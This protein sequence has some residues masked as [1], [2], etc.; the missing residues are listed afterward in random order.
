[1]ALRVRT[2]ESRT[3]RLVDRSLPAARSAR[4]ARAM[5]C[6]PPTASS[7]TAPSATTSPAT[8]S[9]FIVAPVRSSTRSA[10][11]SESGMATRQ[12]TTARHC[13]RNAASTSATSAAAMMAASRRWSSAV[14][15]KLAGRN[16]LELIVTPARPGPI[17]RRASSSRRVRASVFVPGS[18]S[19][20]SWSASS[21]A[22][23]RRPRRRSA[24]VVLD[25]GRDVGPSWQSC[26]PTGTWPRS[27]GPAN[28][29]MCRTPSRWFGPSR[30]P[31]VPGS[32]R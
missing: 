16:A 26:P 24:A 20:T 6:T 21:G 13:M 1:M 22:R 7:T 4:R 32:T 29:R 8:T 9:A 15:M 18:F 25:D 28:G 30:N 23:R 10:V 2:A 5:S 27:L 31:P 19:T 14:S 17:S 12:I 11:R 3:M